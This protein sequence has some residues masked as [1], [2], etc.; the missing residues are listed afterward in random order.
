MAETEELRAPAA[1]GG[2]AASK[3]VTP[4]DSKIT[5]II[6]ATLQGLVREQ[7]TQKVYVVKIDNWFSQ[8]WRG[9]GGKYIGAAGVTWGSG[10]PIPPFHLNRVRAEWQFGRLEC[11]ELAPLYD[12]EPIH[13]HQTSAKNFRRRTY[14]RE[15]PQVWL[16]YSGNTV[17][18]D[19]ASLLVYLVRGL[20]DDE[21]WY[22]EYTKRSE[23]WKISKLIGVDRNRFEG[24]AL[25]RGKS[26]LPWPCP[27]S[28]TREAFERVLDSAP[29]DISA[30]NG[31]SSL[32]AYSKTPSAAIPFCERLLEL[33]PD[34]SLCWVRLG[35]ALTRVGDLDRAESVLK[36]SVSIA[37]ESAMAR[38]YLGYSLEKQD[39]LE[40][41]E[42][43][44]RQAFEIYP[45][46]PRPNA[47]LGH[48][49]LS[50]QRY[51][52]AEPFLRKAAK[53]D[54]E[55][56]HPLIWLAR[57]LVETGREQEANPFV[58]HAIDLASTQDRKDDIEE[59]FLNKQDASLPVSKLERH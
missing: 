10:F 59:E 1:V 39:R 15:T 18:N 2:K 31:L 12:V 5:K 20:G 53:L 13:I 37:P 23:Q 58:R 36:H 22:I 16:W 46:H 29:D 45:T 19:R 26:V 11:G 35:H 52:E 28:G 54:E 44:Y 41:A 3:G 48:I 4:D 33:E 51:E 14:K 49:L 50:L 32:L 25:S 17:Q 24:L 34:N 55:S 57:L 42:K 38:E 9:F 43:C 40:E 30:L 6:E 21:A 47:R 27:A 8:R 56:P 7:K